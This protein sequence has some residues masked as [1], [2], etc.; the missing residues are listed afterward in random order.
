MPLGRGDPGRPPGRSSQV[1]GS[2]LASRPTSSEAVNQNAIDPR[3]G[4]QDSAGSLKG[5]ARLTSTP[6]DAVNGY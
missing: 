3:S 1:A 6:Q 4:V 5:V 2:W